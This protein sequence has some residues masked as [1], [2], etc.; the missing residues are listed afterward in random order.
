VDRR[1]PLRADLPGRL[2]LARR[3]RSTAWHSAGQGR[4]DLPAPQ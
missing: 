4:F 3:D 1:Q 2:P